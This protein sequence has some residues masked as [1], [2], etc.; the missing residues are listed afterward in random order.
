MKF[1]F[2]SSIFHDDG[3]DLQIVHETSSYR[4]HRVM[5]Y[6]CCEYHDSFFCTLPLIHVITTAFVKVGFVN[7]APNSYALLKY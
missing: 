4:A 2:H 3:F 5:Y 7:F 6:Q 1:H